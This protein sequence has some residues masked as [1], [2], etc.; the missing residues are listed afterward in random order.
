MSGDVTLPR[1]F[2]TIAAV[3]PPAATL[4]GLLRM[5]N[6]DGATT[7][8]VVDAVKDV[9]NPKQL[10]ADQPYQ[11][12]RTFDGL[13]REFRYEIDTSKFLRVARRAAAD[14]PAGPFVV[15]VV[16]YPREVQVVAAAAEI[17]QAHN[18]LS[19]ALDAGG[20]NL[21]LALILSDIFGG[22]VDFNSELQRGDRFEVLFERIT[23]EGQFV[24]YGDVSGAILRHGGRTI[25]AIR[26]QGPDGRFAWYDESGRSMKREILKSPL[27][28]NPRITSGFS[29]NRKHPVYGF[30]RAHLGVDYAAPLGSEVI[31]VSAGT[32]VSAGWAGEGGNQVVLHH[33]AGY[34]TYY[35]H[36]SR[37]AA[38][39][40]P[41][42]HVEQKEVIGYVGSTGASTGPH[43][44]YR[45]FR[46]GMFINPVSARQRMPPG[47]PIPSS[48]LADFQV[49]RA[50][51]LADLNRRLSAS[52]TRT[53]E[54]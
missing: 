22:E 41:G 42:Q 19:A 6:V 53:A 21:E 30:S 16:P 10:R 14:D 32:V 3:V 54:H 9:F 50:R 38:G 24:G 27:R 33:S 46:N 13:F 29:M 48:M 18:S 12:T 40:H 44:D 35:L 17:S 51:V 23:R 20:E 2:D 31:A 37:F 34:Q 4:A 45:V 49:T 7:A 39:L 36:L 1:E 28:F 8:A 11:L 26:A 52:L 47:A 25:T 43:L 5:N 15:A